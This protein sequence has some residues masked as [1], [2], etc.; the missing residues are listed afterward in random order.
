[1]GVRG[2]A[3]HLK[4]ACL[5]YMA[6]YP[7][8][9]TAQ[10]VLPCTAGSPVHSDTN[11]TYLGSILLTLPP[12]SIVRYYFIQLSELGVVERTKISML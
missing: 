11:S 1:M 5:F 4:G 12:P 8:H 10:S 9:W 6:P 2:R 3:G 7:V